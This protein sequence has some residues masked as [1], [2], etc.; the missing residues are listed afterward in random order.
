MAKSYTVK[1]AIVADDKFSAKLKGIAANAKTAFAPLGKGVVSDLGRIKGMMTSIAGLAAGFTVGSFVKGFVTAN[2][3]AEALALSMASLVHSSQQAKK[4]NYSYNDS[5]AEGARLTALM[6]K[7]AISTPAS[8]EQI[9]D[10][11]SRMAPLAELAGASLE[12]S[13]KF[14][15]SVA[16]REAMGGGTGQ[17][18][19]DVSTLLRGEQGD[20]GTPQLIA[21]KDKISK[22]M[23]SRSKKKK[24]EGMALIQDALTLSPEERKAAEESWGGQMETFKDQL[25]ELQREAG[26]PLFQEAKKALTEMSAWIR[27]NPEKVRQMARDIGEGILKAAIAIKDAFKWV[28]D[29]SGTIKDVAVA[30]A[31]VWAVGRVGQFGKGVLGFLRGGAGAGAAGGLVGQLGGGGCCCS[32]GVAGAL[33]GPVGKTSGALGKLTDV[34]GRMPAIVAAF[35]TMLGFAIDKVMNQDPDAGLVAGEI[36]RILERDEYART[37]GYA[38]NPQR[39]DM[40]I[41]KDGLPEPYKPTR[42]VPANWDGVLVQHTDE[43]NLRP[44]D[45]AEMARFT[46]SPTAKF[47]LEME[48]LFKDAEG[49]V[50]NAQ[51]NLKKAPAGTKLKGG[52]GPNRAGT[53]GGRQ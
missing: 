32:G 28:V 21:L 44:E 42:H 4:A 26:K 27:E 51:A 5:L 24:A 14:A 10:S 37:F 7:E 33:A 17:V 16:S 6:R 34:L 50:V 35:G 31:G 2:I 46:D 52:R 1:T 19:Q 12:Q 38:A 41:G 36:R 53:S 11:F 30:L 49:A 43:K 29:N 15:A 22:L 23:R 9:A 48:V 40:V 25:K 20:I 18:T 8:F 13:A 45:R 47:A 3:D 39:G